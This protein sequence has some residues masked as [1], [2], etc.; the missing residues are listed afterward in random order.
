MMIRSILKAAGVPGKPARFPDP[1]PVHAVYFDSV[2][3]DGAD[4]GYPFTCAHDCT[5]EL[6]A[7]TITAGDKALAAIGKQLIAAG[8]HYSQQGWYWL[9]A[10][11]RYQNIIEF[12]YTEKF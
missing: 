1:P 4:S 11:Q 12:S 10:I 2:D 8:K 9:S 5:I 6:Y 7:P 3:T